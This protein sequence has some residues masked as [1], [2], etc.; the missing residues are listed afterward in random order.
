MKTPSNVNTIRLRAIGYL[1]KKQLD[2]ATSEIEKVLVLAPEDEEIRFT[3]SVIEYYQAISI[4]S[5][6]SL[7]MDYPDPIESEFVKH[8]DQSIRFLESAEKEFYALAKNKPVESIRRLKYEIWYLACLANNP[9]KEKEAEECSNE[10]LAREFPNYLAVFWALPLRLQIDL[11]NVIVFLEEVI[12]LKPDLNHITALLS[13]YF[14]IKR[15]EDVEKTLHEKKHIYK[16]ENATNLWKIW[17]VKA[18]IAQDK[19]E[20]AKSYF[21]NTDSSDEKIIL[22]YI[23][24]EFRSEEENPKERIAFAERQF[25]ETNDQRIFFQIL[26]LKA[27]LNDWEYIVDKTK[28]LI[29]QIGTEEAVELA[30]ISLFNVRDF[31]KAKQI[32]DEN[33]YRFKQ[34]KLSPKLKRLRIACREELGDLPSAVKEAEDLASSH[35]F[36]ENYLTLA[37]LCFKQSDYVKLSLVSRNI[38]KHKKINAEQ[39]LMLSQWITNDNKRLAIELWN[40]AKDI[41]IPDELVTTAI[42]QGY[43]LGLDRELS[44][45]S[46]RMYNLADKGKGGIYKFEF[47]DLR[48]MMKQDVK[49]QGKLDEM[50]KKGETPIHPLV[51]LYNWLLLDNYHGFLELKEPNPDPMNQIPLFARH[52]GKQILKDFPEKVP[53]WK[54]HLDITA[55]LLAEHLDILK[56]VER[57]FMPLFIPDKTILLLEK[58]RSEIPHHQ[59]SILEAGQ[60]VINLV[61]RERISTAKISISIKHLNSEL[62]EE[63]GNQWMEMYETA[64]INKGR[65][66]VYLPLMNKEFT[67]I[68]EHLPDDSEK[69][70]VS[71]RDL[72][73]VLHQQGPLSSSD[74]TKIIGLLGVEGKK[75]VSANLPEKDSRLYLS[76]SIAGAMVR[77]EALQIIC[78]NFD[79]VIDEIELKRLKNTQIEAKRRDG[80]VKW[81]RNLIS[82]IRDGIDSDTYNLMPLRQIKEDAPKETQDDLKVGNSLDILQNFSPEQGSVIWIDDRCINKYLYRKDKTPIYGIS[83]VLH[84]LVTAGK[85]SKSEYYRKLIQLRAGNVR[86]IPLQKGEIV[87]FLKEAKEKDGQLIETNELKVLRKYLAAC[88]LQSEFLSQPIFKDNHAPDF[89]ETPFMMDIISAITGAI[90]Q[91]WTLKEIDEDDVRLRCEWILNNLYIDHPGMI[92]A[93]SLKFAEQGEKQL[94]A[95]S[96]A[97]LVFE[98]FTLSTKRKKGKGSVRKKYLDWLYNR[99]IRKTLSA[100]PTLIVPISDILKEFMSGPQQD[101]QTDQATEDDDP[102]IMTYVMQNFYYDLPEPLQQGISKDDDFMKSIEMQLQSRV[103]VQGFD[104]VAEDFYE[105]VSKVID[106]DEVSIKL[107]DSENEVIL[108]PVEESDEKGTFHIVEQPNGKSHFAFR[109]ELGVLSSSLNEREELLEQRRAWFDCEEAEFKNA[110]QDIVSTENLYERINNLHAIRKS[111][112]AYFYWDLNNSVNYKMRKQIPFE[113]KDLVPKSADGLLKHY[114]IPINIGTGETFTESINKATSILIKEEGFN[115]AFWRIS[116]LPIALPESLVSA[117]QNLAEKEK[118]IDELFNIAASP[119]S[120]IHL[121]SLLSR[122]TVD[123]DHHK[124]L[125]NALISRLLDESTL[126]SINA[127][128]AVLNWAADEI[129]YLFRD[130]KWSL[131]I[132]LMM[133]WGHAHKIYSMFKSLNAPDD[134]IQ[135]TFEDALRK[136]VETRMPTEMV[137]K[138]RNYWN[139]IAH[140]GFL[141]HRSLILMGTANALKD[142]AGFMKDSKLLDELLGLAFPV[143]NETQNP[144][145]ELMVDSAQAGNVLNSFLGGDRKDRL[146]SLLGNDPAGEYSTDNLK[147]LVKISL[148]KSRI[149][150]LDRSGWLSLLMVLGHLPPYENIKNDLREIINQ[151]DFV[152][153]LKDDMQNGF[154]AIHAATMQIANLDDEKLRGEL[155]DKFIDI[156]KFLADIKNAEDETNLESNYVGRVNE[157]ISEVPDIAM[158]IVYGIQPPLDQMHEL[159]AILSEIIDIDPKLISNLEILLR[160]FCEELPVH[161]SKKFWPLLLRMRVL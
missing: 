82:R 60:E 154:L 127:F 97:K 7:K 92:E 16:K 111:S 139:D 31:H 13:C 156:V 90:T 76:H 132:K 41:G 130:D 124:D 85:L 22:K 47:K 99:L 35:P 103:H 148:G 117:F 134:W 135:Q 109:E 79:V 128:K 143:T 61:D 65:Y 98:G 59:P 67:G 33:T 30:A 55:L 69:Y 94:L 125:I 115:T 5:I 14:T 4:A 100:E 77:A 129:V 157:L 133:M 25:K 57:A 53:E 50:Y 108:K 83:E 93:A 114:R 145:L 51:D 62:L 36:I 116:G 52:G 18:L 120:L 113:I 21:E 74:Y 37:W 123:S 104:F 54:L 151:A 119:I 78:D 102:D 142:N 138:D 150:A 26:R 2:Q 101:D 68:A 118:L 11:S 12:K 146:S 39:T 19:E 70:L 88:M 160:R 42:A 24:P 80:L 17:L 10:L 43:K 56:L 15:Y 48:E 147:E 27:Q 3:A 159:A 112:A 149:S 6:P 141:N 96:A 131:Q 20:E 9:K 107:A 66:V 29:E 1:L 155:K 71:C 63:R 8:D 106:G 91:L 86:Y 45:L 87:H 122:T 95:L 161:Q 105:A 58:L 40:K 32:L 64:R 89:G 144:S 75:P 137:F 72:I 153:L 46:Q 110:V 81:V 73:E 152:E 126:S 23:I 34:S 140:P 28:W 121:I 84:S 49:I 38:I 136:R 44:H 158:K